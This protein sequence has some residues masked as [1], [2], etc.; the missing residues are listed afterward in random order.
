MCIQPTQLY[1]KKN[2]KKIGDCSKAGSVAAGKP[3]ALLSAL[4]LWLSGA[5]VG[6]RASGP[7]GY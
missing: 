5:S 7:F 6:K 3:S 2:I 1:I 4:A